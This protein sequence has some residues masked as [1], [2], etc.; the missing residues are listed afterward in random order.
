MGKV[1]DEI[2]TFRKKYPGTVAWRLK[3]HCEVVEQHLDDDE[4]IEYAFTA[5]KNDN[6]LDFTNTNA[7]VLTNKRMMMGCKRLVFG[8]FL[9]SITPD[10]YNDMEVVAGIIWGK[11]IIDTVKETIVLSDLDKDALPELQNKI[12]DYMAEGKEK[13]NSN[14]NSKD[15]TSI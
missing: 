14:N 13:I 12:T 5:Q 10:L 4:V 2:N 9:T 8:Y 6:P 15:V 1:Y 11:L 3:R 7:I